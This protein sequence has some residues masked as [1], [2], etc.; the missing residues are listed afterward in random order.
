MK[1]IIALLAF[2]ATGAFAH[3]MTPTYFKIDSSYM[4]KVS[5]TKMKLFNRRQ[6]VQ[7][8]EFSV[9]DKEWNPIPFVSTDKLLNLE[10][11]ET[12]TVEI[13]IWDGDVGKVHY[14]CSTSR[15]LKQDVESTAIASKICSKVTWD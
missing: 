3:E 2:V 6:D 4:D 11:L 5:M 7:W 8:Y 1:Y 13:Y 10:Y 14:I 12:E 9:F 15:L